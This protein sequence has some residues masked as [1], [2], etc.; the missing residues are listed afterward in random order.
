MTAPLQLTLSDLQGLQEVADRYLLGVRCSSSRPTSMSYSFQVFPFAGCVAAE[1]VVNVGCAASGMGPGEAPAGWIVS[2]QL[3]GVSRIEVGRRMIELHPGCWMISDLLEPTSIRSS[4]HA[5]LLGLTIPRP[6][7]PAWNGA[8]AALRSRR[9][10][11]DGPVKA[12]AAHLLALLRAGVDLDETS[13]HI[14]REA[15]LGLLERAMLDELRA[16]P[17]TSVRH[18]MPSLQDVQRWIAGHLQEAD[19]SAKTVARAFGIS[20]RTLYNL[21]ATEGTTPRFY[22]LEVRL[23]M[24]AQRLRDPAYRGLT[25]AMIGQQCGFAHPAHMSRCFS[26]AFEMSPARWRELQASA[27]GAEGQGIPGSCA[28]DQAACTPL[29]LRVS[30]TS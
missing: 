14:V 26:S 18:A 7:R 19:L 17:A 29:P 20:R 21:F 11:A 13:Q 27:D 8:A 6:E 24:V 25:V 5:R 9:L 28:T 10:K 1:L 23:Q 16:M 3:A 4:D 12:V 30:S 15:V 2:W 22:I